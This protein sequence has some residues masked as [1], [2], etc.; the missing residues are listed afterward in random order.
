[1]NASRSAP[2]YCLRL[3]LKL[4]GFDDSV[5]GFIVPP[6]KWRGMRFRGG[7]QSKPRSKILAIREEAGQMLSISQ[8]ALGLPDRDAASA[9]SVELWSE[10]IFQWLF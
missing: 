4:G 8:T 5:H 1:M 7:G 3:F 10:C 9:N 6:I 2:F